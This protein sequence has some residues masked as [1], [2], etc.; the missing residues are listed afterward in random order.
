MFTFLSFLLLYLIHFLQKTCILIMLE[1][2]V[3]N[4][5]CYRFVLRTYQRGFMMAVLNAQ[6]YMNDAQCYFHGS[7]LASCY[8]FAT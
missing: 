2:R 7:M 3:G 5:F 6:T 8:V 1:K 4:H